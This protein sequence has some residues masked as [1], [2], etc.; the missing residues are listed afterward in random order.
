MKCT[1]KMKSLTI[2]KTVFKVIN[3][4]TITITT[5]TI[6]TEIWNKKY[7]MF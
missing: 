7:L 2:H 3:N 1:D 5:F 6:G 4:F